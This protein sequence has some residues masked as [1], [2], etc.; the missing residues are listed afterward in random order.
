M[1]YETFD[2]RAFNVL[3]G[4]KSWLTHHD[5]ILSA[6]TDAKAAGANTVIF[7][8]TVNVSLAGEFRAITDAAGGHPDLTE[9]ASAIAAAKA[10]GLAVYLKPHISA[11]DA[12]TNLNADTAG[13]GTLDTANFFANYTTYMSSMASYATTNGVDGIVAGTE[14]NFVDNANRTAWQAL[15]TAIRANFSGVVSYDAMYN[16]TPESVDANDVVFWDL[17]D[18][19]GLSFYLPIASSDAATA[20]QLAEAW[21]T[22]TM[23][24]IPDVIGNLQALAALY[25]KQIVFYEAGYESASGGFSDFSDIVPPSSR[26]VES[27]L[28][29]RAVT[30]LLDAMGHDAGTWFSGLSMWEL[31]PTIYGTTGETT[32][33]FTKSFGVIDKPAERIVQ[34]R[35]TGATSYAN[36][37]YEGSKFGETITASFGDDTVYGGSGSDTLGGGAGN[38]TIYA[39]ATSVTNQSLLIRAYADYVGTA[40]LIT[41]TVN[42]VARATD[43]SISATAGSYTEVTVDLTAI[44]TVTS[45]SIA[46]TND[47]DDDARTLFVANVWLNGYALPLSVGSQTTIFGGHI[48]GD[49]R[50]FDSGSL[51]FDTA[52]LATLAAG[53]SGSNDSVSGGAGDDAIHLSDLTFNS[54]DGGAG[55]DTVALDGSALAF[56]LTS[57]ANTL[58]TGVEVIDLTGTGNNSLTVTEQDVLDLS[59]TSN[60]LRVDGDAG[61]SLSFGGETWTTGATASGYTAYTRGVATVQAKAALA[62][63]A[64]FAAGSRILT[65][66]GEI[67]VEC[68]TDADRVPAMLGKGLRRV[69]WIGQRAVRLAGHPRPWDVQPIA[70]APHAFGP[71]LPHSELVLSPDHAVYVDGALIPVRYLVNG[72]TIRRLAVA[73]VHY[74]HVELA[75]ASGAATHDV[76]LVEGLPTESFL[77]TGNRAAFANGGAETML[78]PDFALKIWE[79]EACAPLVVSGP[80][81]ASVRAAL[82]V[83]AGALGHIT[84]AAAEFHLR[85]DGNPVLGLCVD[86]VYRFTLPDTA[87][88]V[89]LVSLG[90]VPSEIDCTATDTRRLGVAVDR[91]AV[92]GIPLQLDGP[93]LAAGWHAAEAGWRWT[94]GA[95]VVELAGGGLIEVGVA[96][97]AI[98]WG[99]PPQARQTQRTSVT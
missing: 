8:Y 20:T 47:G 70:I 76:L 21:H 13:I 16:L 60:M 36:T 44:G 64:C 50:M 82:L 10:Q 38:D 9:L 15:F 96:M 66:R 32:E 67:A 69:Q 80:A 41:V 83:Q 81:L 33:F 26:S 93:A 3:L 54:I 62:V 52:Q 5:W 57:I 89:Q 24:Q 46:Y 29:T 45:L 88:Q 63:T 85:V 19:I 75:D 79:T 37:S 1:A 48:D 6:V 12:A 11:W 92:N 94:D 14:L 23:G 17:V 59:D 90:S 71:D 86:G 77:D 91:I 58:I 22:N 43:A 55:T 27:D 97:T 35:F 51:I 78:H 42:G 72:A 99:V 34:S 39:D 61:D 4:D 87:R 49:W 84:T 40:P 68:L 31:S 56:N 18:R 74:F 2:F 98:Y 25:G 30:S 28:Q 65:A 73:D 7:D 53:V 95:G